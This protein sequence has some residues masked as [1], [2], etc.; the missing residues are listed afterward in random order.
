MLQTRHVLGNSLHAQIFSALQFMYF[1]RVTQHIS[2]AHKANEMILPV[3]EFCVFYWLKSL[4]N[5]ST[6]R[7]VWPYIKQEVLGRTAYFP[8][9]DAACI[10]NDMSYSSSTA[11]VFIVMVMFLPSCCIATIRGSTKKNILCCN[12]A[13]NFSCSAL[14]ICLGSNRTIKVHFQQG[15]TWTLIAFSCKN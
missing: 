2:Q 12:N 1:C 3:C 11:H 6:Y 8:W 4:M 14:K 13:L 15:I 7:E 9:Y 5:E 10:E